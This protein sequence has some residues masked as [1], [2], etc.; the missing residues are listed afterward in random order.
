[1]DKSQVSQ[2][3][4]QGLKH[5]EIALLL[6]VSKNTLAHFCSK[7][8]L[9]SRTPPT[10][11]IDIDRLRKLI[12]VDG[13]QQWKA[14][15]I[16][17]CTR[18]TI[19]RWCRRL[20]LTTH[21]TGPRSGAGHTNW[22]GGKILVGGYFY[23]YCPDHPYKTQAGRVAEHRLVMESVLK[24]FLLPSEVVHHRNGNPQDNR[25]E[26][27]ECFQSNAT[28]L[29]HELTGKIPQWTPAGFAK[30]CSPRKKRATPKG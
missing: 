18:A 13:L 25:P 2:L 19:E 14:A 27:L 1:M 7:N 9:L 6:G 3:L 16:L 5:A 22:K 29:K 20:G 15:E 8:Q 28:H 23:I 24:R 26:N 21:R 12:E 11:S 30:M 10:P 17:N 4:K